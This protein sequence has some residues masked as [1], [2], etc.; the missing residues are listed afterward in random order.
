MVT[1][2][3]LA[4]TR[5]V[6]LP[7]ALAAGVQ[8]LVRWRR[9]G[10]TPFDLVERW[11]LAMSAAVLVASAALWPLITGLVVGDLSAYTKTQ[12]A[13]RDVAG[14]RPDTWLVSLH[15]GASGARWVVVM[16]II[17]GAVG[18][19]RHNRHWTLGTRIWV[20][21]YPAYILAATPPTSSIFRY[22]LLTGPAWWP[23]PGVQGMSRGARVGIVCLVTL[24][25]F[26]AQLWWI[27]RYLV[28][29]PASQGTP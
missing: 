3:A 1:G 6:T 19:A 16:L 18:V 20:A 25:G 10:E 7:L 15:D 5:P 14:N 2:L 17:A 26:A 12:H 8:W 24:V 27:S 11:G 9:R 21:T 22:A 29:T 28:I 4:L 13:W 23:W